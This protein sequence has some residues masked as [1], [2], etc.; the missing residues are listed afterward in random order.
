MRNTQLFKEQLKTVSTLMTLE[1]P[2]DIKK[3]IHTLSKRATRERL[4][5]RTF[6]VHAIIR[7]LVNNAIDNFQIH[8]LHAGANTICTIYTDN[9]IFEIDIEYEENGF[10]V[11]GAISFPI[12]E[13]QRLGNILYYLFGT[14]S[15]DFATMTP[16]NIDN[17][18]QQLVQSFLNE[19]YFKVKL[20]KRSENHLRE[21]RWIRCVDVARLQRIS[22]AQ[23]QNLDA[24]MDLHAVLNAI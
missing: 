12:L 11:H 18:E 14:Y 10:R 15:W 13:T 22:D 6:L 9:F 3:R 24:P 8:G 4:S 20:Y 1:L 5:R 17:D 19:E 16:I 23:L 2:S 7:S 21:M